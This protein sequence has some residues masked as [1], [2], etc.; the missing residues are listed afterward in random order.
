MRILAALLLAVAAAPA[1]SAETGGVVHAVYYEAA[2]GV[3]VDASILVRPG[4]ARWA[5]VE[6][7]DGRRTLAQLPRHLRARAGDTVAIQLGDP[8]STVV[9]GV[10]STAGVLG[11]DRIVAVGVEPASAGVGR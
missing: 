3:M 2:R 8:K 10:L 5:D 6:L 4:A 7:A 9:S 11:T 1:Y